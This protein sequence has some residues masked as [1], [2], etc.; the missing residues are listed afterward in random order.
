MVLNLVRRLPNRFAAERVRIHHAGPIGEEIR[1]TGVP[2]AVLGLNPGT[3]APVR[4]CLAARVSSRHAAA[5]CA[6]VSPH[7]QPLRPLR[8]HARRRAD[9]HRHRSEH[10][11]AQA[12]ASHRRR[13]AADEGD[14]Y[15]RG[16]GGIGARVL[17]R[18]GARPIRRAS[19]SST[20]RSTGRSSRRPVARDAMR[21]AIGVPRDAHAITIIARLTEQKA[22]TVLFDALQQTPALAAAHLRRRGRR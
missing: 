6:H 15:G 13:A 18:S 10:L 21:D 5:D 12:S 3:T 7:R 11:R 19:R 20:T 1:A 14:R 16:I 9:H 2:F 22:H 4:P 17:H 8:R